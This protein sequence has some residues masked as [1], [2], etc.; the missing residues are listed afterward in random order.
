M[1]W[2]L[3]EAL[4]YLYKA[5]VFLEINIFVIKIQKSTKN[6]QSEY[7]T[8]MISKFSDHLLR[9]IDLIQVVYGFFLCVSHY[10]I[11]MSLRLARRQ[12]W[13]LRQ[14]PLG[15][16]KSEFDLDPKF[17]RNLDNR[18]WRLFDFVFGKS[19][20]KI[21]SVRRKIIKSFVSMESYLPNMRYV[22]QMSRN[23]YFQIQMCLKRN[24][25]MLKSYEHFILTFIKLSLEGY[26]N[27]IGVFTLIEY[28]RASN[29][30]NLHRLTI[31]IFLFSY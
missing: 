18:T 7:R 31:D 12:F 19:F 27:P 5:L 8:E 9:A 22:L 23:F 28:S 25:Q 29:Q 17:V 6:L 2:H 14:G 21:K 11:E 26:Y 10:Y 24:Y 15:Y 3:L 4:K 1:A 20:D 30:P 16:W 13:R